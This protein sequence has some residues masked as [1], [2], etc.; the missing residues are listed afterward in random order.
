MAGIEW[1]RASSTGFPPEA[2]VQSTRASRSSAQ[3]PPRSSWARFSRQ[4]SG[5]GRGA[6]V[7]RRSLKRAQLKGSTWPARRLP[8]AEYCSPSHPTKWSSSGHCHR[9]SQD[10]PVTYSLRHVALCSVEL[11]PIVRRRRSS[12]SQGPVATSAASMGSGV[13]ESQVGVAPIRR[14]PGG[15]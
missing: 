14:R 12:V 9:E 11:E 8:G 13:T 3:Q 15:A 7:C 10:P 1:L 2:L 6:V 4:G 5:R